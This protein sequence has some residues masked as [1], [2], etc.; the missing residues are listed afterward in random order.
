MKASSLLA[1]ARVAAVA[2]TTTLTAC[3]LDSTCLDCV[4]GDDDGD[5]GRRDGGVDANDGGAPPDAC[6]PTAVD[7]TCN[8]IDDDCDGTVDE[9]VL[10]VGDACSTDVGECTVGVVTCSAGQLGCSGVRAT[11][12]SCDNLD[13]DCDGDFDEGNPQGGELCGSDVGECV[14]GLT[15]C[16]NGAVDCVGDVGTPGAVAEACDGLDNDCDGMFDEGIA[17]MGTCGVDTGECAFGALTCVG[18]GVQCIGGQGPVLELCDAIDQDCDG[19]NANGFNLQ[20]DIANC[21]T[22]GHSCVGE[23]DNASE[24]CLAGICDVASCDPGYFDNDNLAATGCEYGPCTF[25]GPVEACNNVDDDCDGTVDENLAAPPICSQLGACAGTTAVC[26]PT[27]YDCVYTGDVSVDAMGNLV[28]E[29]E[30]DGVDNDCDGRVDESRPVGEA[31]NDGAAGVCRAF[32]VYECDPADQDAPVVCTITTPGQAPSAEICDNLDNNCVGGVDEGAATGLLQSWVSLGGGKQIMQYEASKPD[33]TATAV[34]SVTTFACSKPGV[35]PWT[36]VTQ[37]EAEAACASIGARLCTEQEWHQACSVRSP[38][39]FPLTEPAGNNGYMFIEAED[40]FLNTPNTSGGVTRAW[41]PDYTPGFSGLSALRA[42]PNTGANLGSTIAD[43]QGPR[44]DFPINFTQTGSHYVWVRAYS[45]TSSDDRVWVGIST[46]PATTDP[47][48]SLTT[49]TNNPWEW[50][51]TGAINVTA[52]GVR[53]VSLYMREDGLKVDAI[54]ITR[55]NSTTDP[56]ENSNNG[57]DWAFASNPDTFVGT[58]CNGDA[59]DT[60]PAAGDQDRIL[61]TGTVTGGNCYANGATTNDA[62]DMTGNVKEWTLERTPGANPARGGA[63]NNVA[64][65]L[66]CANAFTLANDA[67]FFPNVGF[68]CCR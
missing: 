2:L 46:A 24:R 41:V 40:H 1:V 39:T 19:N 27:G 15:T 29:T 64:E 21:G 36:N 16:I 20:I 60:D 34:G 45:P 55:L 54:V 32:G 38:T 37:P 33:A 28:P 53:T 5:G 13:N 42:S 6:I 26:T 61:P 14:A 63:S 58:T 9:D 10:T 65:G 44:L 11:A 62:F 43:S 23:L 57:G 31:C 49:A 52:T 7:E 47:T 4:T 67:F 12:E 68:R 56:T 17:S 18:G 48:Q 3:S 30:C 8:D 51:R 50:E 35:Q 25:A 22:C 59:Y 66:T